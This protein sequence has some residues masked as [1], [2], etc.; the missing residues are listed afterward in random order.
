MSSARYC[1]N[2]RKDSDN[3][4]QMYTVVAPVV[5]MVCPLSNVQDAR[6]L[7]RLIVVFIICTFPV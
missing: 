2:S 3:I 6:I 4:L 1:N 7:T 5:Y